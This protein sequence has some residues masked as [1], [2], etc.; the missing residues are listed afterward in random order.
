MLLNERRLYA[1]ATTSVFRRHKR[2]RVNE[3]HAVTRMHAYTHTRAQG[4]LTP[5][6]L[7]AIMQHAELGLSEPE[8]RLIVA[9]ADENADG[10]IDVRNTRADRAISGLQ[11]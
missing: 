2:K 6:Q 9:E 1:I 8:L 7:A 3:M 4:Y 5:E 10:N 11:G